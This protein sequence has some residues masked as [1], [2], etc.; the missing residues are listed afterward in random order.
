MMDY[1]LTRKSPTCPICRKSKD[2]GLVVCWP[3]HRR[4]KYGMT[5]LETITLTVNETRLNNGE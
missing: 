3:C 4:T 1:P 2:L 5:E